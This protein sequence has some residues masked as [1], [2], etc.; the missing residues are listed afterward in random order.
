[1]SRIANSPV[2][3]PKG[4]EVTLNDSTLSVKGGN[5]NLSLDLNEM[6]KITHEGDELK[7]SATQS[8]KKSGA[9]AGTFRALAGNMVK[10]VSEGFVKQLQLV[11]VGYR[12]QVQGKKLNLNLGFSHPVAY[13]VPEGVTVEM[14]SQTE[15]LVKGADKQLVGQVAA[16]IRAFR[17]PE[18]YKGKGVRY[19]DEYVKRKDAKKK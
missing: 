5:G 16:E 9:L 2:E 8:G 1:M 6:V 4:V 13:N 17:S 14:P 11:G 15:I 3:I 7:F 18:P 19:V 12:G 10:G